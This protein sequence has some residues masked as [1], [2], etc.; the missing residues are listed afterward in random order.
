MSM[1]DAVRNRKRGE[2]A[3]QRVLDRTYS[4]ATDTEASSDDM[5]AAVRNRSLSNP[6]APAADP[7]VSEVL[8]STLA[9]VGIQT[10]Q[11]KIDMSPK[12]TAA[13]PAPAG[14]DF[15]AQQAKDK[16][17]APFQ[18]KLPAPSALQMPQQTIQQTLKDKVPAAD[19]LGKPIEQKAPTQYDITKQEIADSGAPGIIKT[20]ADAMNYLARGN[21]VG[22]A[23]SNS[24]AGNSGAVQRDSTGNKVVDK[25]TDIV[26][27]F[28]TPLLVPSGAPVGTGPN[29][30][31][32]EV[33]GKALSKGMGQAAV[34]KVA[35]GISKVAPKVSPATAQTIARQGLTETIAGPLQG[36]GIGLMNQQDSNAEIERN[37]LYGAAGGAA[38]GFGG[39]ALGAGAKSLFNRFLQ[40][41]G[42]SS[43]APEVAPIVPGDI[44]V[45]STPAS[46]TLAL[47]EGR[48]SQRDTRLSAASKRS[49]LDPGEEAII[50]PTDWK[51]EPLGLPAADIAP[52]TTARKGTK[53]GL[54]RILEQMKPI[55][56]ERMT[57][58]LENPNELAKWIQYHF[59]GDVSLNEIRQLGYEDMRQLGE[60]IRK[61]ITVEDTARSVAKELGYDLDE[62]LGPKTVDPGLVRKARRTQEVRDTYG[63]GNVVKSTEDRYTPFVGEA[64][65]PETIARLRPGPR[66]TRVSGDS[67]NRF[68]S[69]PTPSR[70]EIIAAKSIKDLTQDDIAYL[71][72]DSKRLAAEGGPLPEIQINVPENI[73][74]NYQRLLEATTDRAPLQSKPKAGANQTDTVQTF[75]TSKGST[76]SVDGNGRTVRDKALH[77]GH[78]PSDVG[79][80]DRSEQ[81]VYVNAADSSRVGSHFGLN[82]EARPKVVVRD[83]GIHLL[84]WNTAEGRWGRNGNPIPYTT[85][86]KVGESPVELWGLKNDPVLGT[87][88]SKVHAG[89]EI[90]EVG[91]PQAKT[92]AKT[93]LQ[94]AEEAVEAVTKSNVR[95]R[96]YNLLDDAEKA[97]RERI[98]KR[99]GNINSNPLPEWADYSIIM[100]AK[101]GKGTIKA[102]NFAEEL[103]KE[104]GENVRPHADRILR[105]T[106]EEIRK[107]ERLASKEGQAAAVANAVPEG[108]AA[109]FAEKVSRTVP[110][111]KKPFAERWQR[112]RTQFS[113]DLAALE[114][115]ERGLRGGKLASAEDSLYKSARLYKGAPER[116]AQIVETRL[117]PVIKQAEAAGYAVEDLE[118]YALAKHAA[119]MNAAGYE[120][121][122]TNQEIKDVLDSFDSPEMISAHK[123]LLQVN[124]DMLQELVDSGV[125]SKDLQE[126]LSDRWKNYIPMFRAFDDDKVGFAGGLTKSLAN[127]TAPIKTL[128]GSKRKVIRPL[129]NMVKNIFQSVNA[130]ERNKVAAQIPKLAK[131]DTEGQYIRKVVDKHYATVRSNGENLRY[132]IEPATFEKISSM[133]KEEKQ[134][135]AAEMSG[136]PEATFTRTS[137]VEDNLDRKNVVKVKVGGN[138]ELYEVEPEVYKALMN[139]DKESSNTLMNMLAKPASLLRAGATLTPEFALRNPIRDINAAYV[140][141][142]SGFNPITDF[143]AGLIQ[144]IKKGPLYREWI[145]NLGAYGNT[146]SMD[147]KVHQQALQT[148]LK[149][150]NTKKFVNVING[151]ALIHLLRMIS[152]TTESATKVGEYRAALRSGASPQEAAYR[153]R[154][155]M[156]FAKAGSSIRQANKIV[157]FLNANIQGKSKLI[158]AIKADPV[159]VTT[160]AL[161]SVTIPTAA[162]FLHN[163]LNAN[164]TQRDT[165]DNAPDWQKDSFWM[166]AVPGIDKVAR[167]P[168]PFDLAAIFS[169]LPERALEFVVKKDKAAFDGFARRS[170]KDASLPSQISGMLPFFEGAANYSFFREGPIIPRAEQGLEWAD[171]YDPIRTTETAKFL[172]KGVEKVTG[173]KGAAK[174]FSSP[175]VMDSTIQGL[176]AGLGKYATDA[177]DVLLKGSGIVDRPS[178]P[179]KRAEQLPVIRSF[180]V[181]SEQGGKRLDKLY[182]LKEELTKKKASAKLNKE[183]FRDAATL[184][185]LESVTDRVSKLNKRIKAIERGNLS[186]KEKQERISEMTATRNRIVQN[187]MKSVQ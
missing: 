129:E 50:N 108:D 69:V 101:L 171:Q 137:S 118:H 114:N 163:H 91:S 93:V 88:A 102:T 146:L 167:I 121:G 78:S 75:R 98:A 133:T 151:K 45:Q 169:N 4:P 110:D 65:A 86:P 155:L 43:A 124:K 40:N 168:K 128:Q 99:R 120:S 105:M 1:F 35:Q 184:K 49:V 97:A 89:N 96:V 32:Y 19:L 164:E 46:P 81:T 92:A 70:D 156:D 7:V 126:V 27:D 176:T 123:A 177:I 127:V 154:D 160:R 106:K 21:P 157:A 113:D 139:L 6:V 42:L 51:P 37:A 153:S 150:G 14:I 3:K 90:T 111:K 143:G 158:R 135:L 67:L 161:T 15:K 187:V 66:K 186:R 132:E 55:V 22:R 174:N 104:F 29:I 9:G 125:V 100:A 68:K 179:A 16:Q 84:S 149:E 115:A 10:G 24:F 147:R 116:A 152:D 2:D 41:K 13:Q 109:S 166:I 73:K 85:S 122:F 48:V 57:P 145:D 136:D 103:V 141:S 56:D 44:P 183:P 94:E 12:P 60:E 148:V 182:Q 25:A 11:P 180:L 159:G 172:A 131:L 142:E 144:T 30:G 33:A 58:P 119:D 59:G 52:P 47:P 95:D 20:Y 23:V 64:A 39:A 74:G 62:L 79:I 138:D 112:W 83:D 185:R 53:P 170:L 77:E 54:N 38:L 87:T 175:R 31:A 18:G 28:I 80:K 34:N 165:L 178:A 61:R 117:G 72:E 173:G 82:K 17:I 26:N 181:D 76:Y 71:L 5:F 8:R 162:I 107:Q 36:V 134:A 140:S 63:L 130:A